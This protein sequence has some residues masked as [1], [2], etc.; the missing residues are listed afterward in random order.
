MTRKDYELIA[1][2]IKNAHPW[3]N[4]GMC[5]EQLAEDMANALQSDNP[6][7]CRETFLQAATV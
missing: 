2:V 7:F 3:N 1:R 6:K 4:G 5:I